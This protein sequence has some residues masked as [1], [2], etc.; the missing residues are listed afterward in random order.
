MVIFF[1]DFR[2]IET[3]GLPLVIVDAVLVLVVVVVVESFG[4]A[5]ALTPTIS[6][7]SVGAR[8]YNI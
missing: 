8:L 7:I 5:L 4:S 2:I 1:D 3:V 6:V